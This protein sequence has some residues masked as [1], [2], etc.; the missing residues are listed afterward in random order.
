M[1]DNNK[2]LNLLVDY[3]GT[4]PFFTGVPD[5]LLKDFLIVLERS[6]VHIDKNIT[7]VNEGSALALATGYHLATGNTPIVYLQNSGLGNLVNPASSLINSEVNDIPIVFLIGYRGSPD[8][9]DEPQHKLMGR[10]TKSI[11]DSLNI[12]WFE[13]RDKT[14]ILEIKRFLFSSSSIRK[15][16]LFLPNALNK[17]LNIL[18]ESTG[19]NRKSAIGLITNFFSD[20]FYVATTGKVGRELYSIRLERGYDTSYDFLNAGSMGHATSIALGLA[21][22]SPN[23]RI[24]LLDGDGAFLMHLGSSAMISD[25]N[26][27]NLIHIIFDNNAHESVGGFPTSI[28][29][30]SLLDIAKGFSYPNVYYVEDAINLK[31]I[32]NIIVNQNELSLI[33]VKTL[34][35]SDKSLVRPKKSFVEMKKDFMTKIQN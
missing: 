2:L 20:A 4:K 3:I 9:D 18:R 10:A 21:I 22:K 26:P 12:D 32:L 15:A 28:N 11:L 33:V 24:I 29:R 7:A 17:E 25:I 6:G 16:L 13:I 1:I 30:L 8:I 23:K 27:N 5:S 31:D 35:Y 34:I 14:E 19:I